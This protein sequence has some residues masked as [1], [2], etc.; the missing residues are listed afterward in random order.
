MNTDI[1]PEAYLPNI[2]EYPTTPALLDWLS[3]HLLPIE[4]SEFHHWRGIKALV[5]V[6]HS[7]VESRAVWE[8]RAAKSAV[9]Q[10]NKREGTQIKFE[11]VRDLDH[12]YIPC[13]AGEW[14][15][16]TD[17]QVLLLRGDYDEPYEAF[18]YASEGVNWVV[19]LTPE[20][21]ALVFKSPHTAGRG[22]A[23]GERA[24]GLNRGDVYAYILP[25]EIEASIKQDIHPTMPDTV[26]IDRYPLHDNPND[27]KYRGS[28]C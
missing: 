4:E 13:G 28:L 7:A 15:V 21:S 6:V 11:E 23:T 3:H 24:D 19:V 16:W 12:T 17:N 26:C 22:E 2:S 27:I 1:S 5:E 14:V 25:P 10:Y 8:E 20:S 18:F 9:E